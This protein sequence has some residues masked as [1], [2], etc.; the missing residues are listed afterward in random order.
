MDLNDIISQLLETTKIEE[1]KPNEEFKNNPLG[2]PKFD[3]QN[4]INMGIDFRNID[5]MPQ[6]FM[7][8]PFIQEANMMNVM[9]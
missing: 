7:P 5:N 2:L 6:N 3:H 8:S 1:N 4:M 9:N